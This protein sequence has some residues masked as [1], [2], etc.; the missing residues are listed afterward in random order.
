M[1][2]KGVH[3]ERV[4]SNSLIPDGPGGIHDGRGS[5]SLIARDGNSEETW[6]IEAIR[7]VRELDEASNM[8]LIKS[9]LASV[10]EV[11]ARKREDVWRR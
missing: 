9:V 5:I 2:V 10:V 4:G 8:V 3:A 11:R 7:R 1:I 6:D